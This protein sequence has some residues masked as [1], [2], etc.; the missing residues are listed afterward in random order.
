MMR[1]LL[2]AIFVSYIS[3]K[4]PG[5]PLPSK[6]RP[7]ASRSR[8][9][10]AS[11][12]PRKPI[13]RQPEEDFEDDL[14]DE[15]IIDDD[16]EED[17]V[18]PKRRSKPS[19]STRHRTPKRRNPP[20]ARRAAPS[21][22][23]P[24]EPRR[25]A[26][27]FDDAEEDLYE[28]EYDEPYPRPRSS[29][30]PRRA[31]PPPRGGRGGRMVP[32]TQARRP[33]FAATFTKGLAAVGKAL[34]D[35][36]DKAVSGLQN[37]RTV[38]GSLTSNLVREIKGVTSSE[39]EQVLLKATRPDDQSSKGKHVER[40]IGVTYQ[41]PVSYDVYDAL[42]R[43]IWSKMAEPDWRTNLKAVYILHRFSADGSPTHAAALK[44]RLRELRRTNDP[45]RRNTKY[46][47]SK[48]LLA[49]KKGNS[50]DI[51]MF[52][53][54]VGRY[55]HYVLL[56]TQCFSG[57]FDEIGKKPGKKDNNLRKEHLN[58]ASII[59]KAALQCQLKNG[60]ECENTAIAME[61]V[62]ADMM[63]LSAAVA[64]S[65]N[66]A[67]LKKSSSSPEL[68]KDWCLFYK[69]ELLPKTKALVKKTTGKLDA[70][71]LFLPSRIGTS[72][73]PDVLE[74]GLSME[75]SPE[76]AAEELSEE[77]IADE[78]KDVEEGTAVAEKRKSR[79]SNSSSA[80]T[81]V[82]EAHDEE[83]EEDEEETDAESVHEEPKVAVDEGDDRVEEEAEI[84]EEYEYDEEEFYDEE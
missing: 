82:K 48:V 60:E 41:I 3:A 13:Q 71:G 25:R 58:A 44:A 84:D 24:V 66:R 55:A 26:P 81:K 30:G 28:D 67:I 80:A 65:L 23:R 29:R 64:T 4:K 51:E 61:R 14:F 22:R 6:S 56:R 36:K 8:R 63:A 7:S 70:Y 39:L 53:A 83:E 40:L 74:R 31:G 12:P 75:A 42:L 78:D 57:M 77:V 43:K 35:V 15:D 32:Y 59:L 34:P 47:S 17:E 27:A 9:S 76:A 16:E 18:L 52:R 72:V 19:P 68:I 37:A 5:R 20:P 62:C 2:V 33:T 73:A 54:F 49:G 11:K 46:F 79:P 45:K 1:L 10:P 69:D 21:R 38:T 50:P